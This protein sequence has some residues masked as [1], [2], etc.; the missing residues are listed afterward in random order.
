MSQSSPIEGFPIGTPQPDDLFVVARL[1]GF[2]YTNFSYSLQAIQQYLGAGNILDLGNFRLRN[3]IPGAGEIDLGQDTG[4]YNWDP[5][6]LRRIRLSWE[7]DSGAT[8]YEPV[9]FSDRGVLFLRRL[10]VP[11]FDPIVVNVVRRNGVGGS[12][13][14]MDLYVMSPDQISP[15][16]WLSLTPME[17]IN[18]LFIPSSRSWP[19]W[20]PTLTTPGAFDD[21]T[22]GYRMG[23]VLLTSVGLF[24]CTADTAFTAAW[25]AIGGGGGSVK[26]LK[27][28]MLA[29]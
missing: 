2:Q 7:P 18:V 24:R 9:I 15:E 23:D 13:G 12:P 10:D 19:A 22:Q 8:S 1:L 5:S 25:A 26:G 21:A 16:T 4:N 3:S 17:E 20:H 6:L 27:I 11:S 28:A 29:I 14:Y